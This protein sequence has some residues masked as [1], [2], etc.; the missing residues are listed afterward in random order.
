[1]ITSFII[2]CVLNGQ[3]C[4]KP[5]LMQSA[6]SELHVLP[7]CLFKE[8][9]P[10][11]VSQESQN[12]HS[13]SIFP[14]DYAGIMAFLSQLTFGKELIVLS[15]LRGFC[16]SLAESFFNFLVRLILAQCV[17]S[18]NRRRNP[19]DKRYLQKQ[20]DNARNGPTDCEE[21]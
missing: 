7:P 2:H 4:Q 20:T 18:P 11:D 17:H 10:K 12:V 16:T 15:L 5:R 9:P 1:M 13:C 3:C 6:E 19:A 14:N 8:I 21:G